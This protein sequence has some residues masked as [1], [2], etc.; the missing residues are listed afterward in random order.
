MYEEVEAHIQEMLDIGAIH[1]SNSLWACAVVLVQ[2]NDGKLQ[3]CIELR[4]L[5]A[6]TVKDVYSLS[7]INETLDCLNG[8]VWFMSLYLKLGYWQEEME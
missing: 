3:F 2:K 1:P 7:Q 8:A 5:N 6:Q 4:R